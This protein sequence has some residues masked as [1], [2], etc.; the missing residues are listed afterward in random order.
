[1][2]IKEERHTDE[3]GGGA[4][5]RGVGGGREEESESAIFGS[6]DLGF[7]Y[8]NFELGFWGI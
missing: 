2:R 7:V 3:S 4:T 6:G 1:M 8:L 5:V